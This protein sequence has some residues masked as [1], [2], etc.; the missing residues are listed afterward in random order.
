M[1]NVFAN[2][3]NEIHHEVFHQTAR[4]PTSTREESRLGELFER[5]LASACCQIRRRVQEFV[6]R[7]VAQDKRR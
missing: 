1:K 3:H 7:A 6:R 4:L 2:T 5:Q